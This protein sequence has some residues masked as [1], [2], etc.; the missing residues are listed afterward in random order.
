MR[1]C[2]RALNFKE[3]AKEALKNKVRP[4]PT[5]NVDA[6]SVISNF[7]INFAINKANLPVYYFD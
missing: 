3:R 1:T 2:L 5:K 7:F 4:L 6:G